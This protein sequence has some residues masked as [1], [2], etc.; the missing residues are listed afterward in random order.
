MQQSRDPFQD[1]FT[2]LTQLDSIGQES[3][4]GEIQD[5]YQN[6][7]FSPDQWEKLIGGVGENVVKLS[8]QKQKVDFWSDVLPPLKK[9][10]LDASEKV[11][12][13][14][15]TRVAA[16]QEGKGKGSINRGDPQFPNT[17]KI[18]C[19]CLG[20]EDE[21]K[22]EELENRVENVQS[23]TLEMDHAMGPGCISSVTKHEDPEKEEAIIYSLRGT[24]YRISM[25]SDTI[26]DASSGT[27]RQSPLTPFGTH[28]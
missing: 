9:P 11:R 12:D 1:K 2:R 20:G 7:V 5:A 23:Y 17:E 15:L 22:V 16:A 27:P 6:A 26:G 25:K 4:Q 21:E 8:K 3:W 18:Y 19:K 28:Q 13:D 24:V 14:F 10:L